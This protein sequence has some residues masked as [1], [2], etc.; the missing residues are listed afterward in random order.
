MI[1]IK[2]II[3][4]VLLAVILVVSIVAAIFIGSVN[5]RGVWIFQI[6]VNNMFGHEIF[7]A[8]WPASV[9]SIVWEIRFPRVLLAAVVGA[10]LSV[11][12]IAMQALTKNS[13]ADPYVLGI[14][15]GA[16]TGAV[17]SILLG[18]FAVPFG[19]FLGAALSMAI[20]FNIA[21]LKGRVT[22]TRLVLTGVAVSAMFSSI[23]SFMVFRADNQN[24]VRSVLFWM[25][26]SLGGT[27]W[28]YIMYTFVVLVLCSAVIYIFSRTL[29]AFLLGDDTAVTLGIDVKK[30]KTIIVL[31][32]TLLTGTMVS[33]SG[34]IGFVGLVVPHICRS[35]V[36]SK[37]SR[38]I[39][40][41]I[42][43]GAI[44]LIWVDVFS[45]MIASPEELPIGIVTSLVGAPFFL[46][47]LRKSNYM[48]GGN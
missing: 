18:I 2:N 14:S 46:W 4:Y 33:A 38:I 1:N 40:V 37:H 7:K 17:V 16:S 10:G 22:S 20:V 45:R 42:F 9:N 29:D 34:V 8:V 6:I 31:V 36:G 19:A 27:T 5:I 3:L 15:S 32:S 12:G 48:F 24:K 28:N 35:I 47:I 44:F 30:S 43:S 41:S 26:G 25:E 39:P 23:T 13:L 11:S 21:G